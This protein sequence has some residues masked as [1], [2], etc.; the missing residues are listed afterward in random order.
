MLPKAA[1]MMLQDMSYC[2]ALKQT[3]SQSHLKTE[4]IVLELIELDA[5]DESCFYQ[6]TQ[7]LSKCGF[8]LAIDDYGVNASTIERVESVQPYIIKMDRSLLVKYEHGDL[9]AL[10]SALLLAKLTRENR[11]RRN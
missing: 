6:S 9:S 8:K 5:N 4:Q 3:I 1:E 10:T 2:Q 7:E 11:Y